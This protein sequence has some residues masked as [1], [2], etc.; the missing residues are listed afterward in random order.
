MENATRIVKVAWQVSLCFADLHSYPPWLGSGSERMFLWQWQLQI[1]SHGKEMV[2]LT[3][4]QCWFTVFMIDGSWFLCQS[5][6]SKTNKRCFYCHS[7]AIN[8][9]YGLRADI[10]RG[11]GCNFCCRVLH[12]RLSSG[13]F[14]RHEVPR[15]SEHPGRFSCSWNSPIHLFIRW[16]AG[17]VRPRCCLEYFFIPDINHHKSHDNHDSQHCYRMVIVTFI[18]RINQ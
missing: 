2:P 15:T 14:C 17:G 4:A 16:H 11:A 9:A 10:L 18:I 3:P 12:S 7:S 13:R 5:L 8:K 1:P 6:N